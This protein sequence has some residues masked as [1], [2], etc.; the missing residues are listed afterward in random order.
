MISSIQTVD[1]QVDQIRN[2]KQYR[3]PS[4]Y[5]IEQKAKNYQI[6]TQGKLKENFPIQNQYNNQIPKQDNLNN[7]IQKTNT[8]NIAQTQNKIY[9]QEM[10]Q[11]L[12]Q[13][14]VDQPL[15]INDQQYKGINMKEKLIEFI[16]C[17]KYFQ[18]DITKFQQSSKNN[19]TEQHFHIKYLFY[20]LYPKVDF[21]IWAY[22][23]QRQDLLQQLIN[24][25]YYFHLFVE[26]QRLIENNQRSSFQSTQIQLFINLMN[27]QIQ[28]DK[29]LINKI[30]EFLFLCKDRVE[31]QNYLNYIM[32]M[33][34]PFQTTYQ[35]DPKQNQ[36]Q[37][38]IYYLYGL[39]SH[40]S[41]SNK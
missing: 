10:Q 27:I 15:I 40:F 13:S 3:I 41:V 5:E 20:D 21:Q 17:L 35:A 24:L 2:S 22:N 28:Q 34:D 36:E 31:I 39:Y 19:T 25:H 16:N 12:V 23:F 8:I 9:G 14:N 11:P 29:F 26:Y 37:D 6:M 4:H 32:H 33:T 1:S 30:L 18:V 7:N 38:H